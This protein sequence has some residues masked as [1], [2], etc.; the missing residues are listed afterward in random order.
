MLVKIENRDK[1]FVRW[2]MVNTISYVLN[3]FTK[4]S[5]HLII[6][7]FL[8]YICFINSI[9]AREQLLV[10]KIMLERLECFF[11]IISA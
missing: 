10:W 5:S 8:L 4:W 7:S 9:L 11:K 6:I 3:W 1:M 2:T